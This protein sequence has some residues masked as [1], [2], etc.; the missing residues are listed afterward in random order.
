LI[1]C[2]GLKNR[3]YIFGGT[4]NIYIELY[5]YQQIEVICLVNWTAA[6]VGFVLVVILSNLFGY[7]FGF[8]G[9][10]IGLFIAGIVV[11]LMVGG[12]V[13]TGF[14][15]GLVAG[16]FGAIVISIIL[17]IGGTITAGLIGF[18]TV[19]IASITWIIYIFVT[20]GFVVGV[21]GAIGSLISGKN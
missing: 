18:T 11:G 2:S 10:S 12:G 15:N 16:A 7:F 6:F 14:G 9:I 5:Y 20:S 19:A 17:L 21:G 13:L 3:V 4:Y 8:I 1:N